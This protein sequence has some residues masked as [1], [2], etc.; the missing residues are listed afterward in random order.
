MSRRQD[1]RFKIME[2]LADDRVKQRALRERGAT[3]KWLEDDHHYIVACDACAPHLA[4]VGKR[5]QS[6]RMAVTRMQRHDLKFHRIEGLGN[7]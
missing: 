6:L 5:E 3:I 1:V 2:V 4:K 7:G